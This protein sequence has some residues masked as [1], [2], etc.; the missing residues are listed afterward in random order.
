M[1]RRCFIALDI[2]EET[3][4]NIADIQEYIS[5]EKLFHGKF[6]EKENMH[7][8]LKFLGKIDD[9]TIDRIRTRLSEISME[10]FTSKIHRI[11]VFNRNNVR[12]IWVALDDDN[13]I[14]LQDNVDR[15]MEELF[16]TENR[17]MGHI[18]IARVKEVYELKR[19]LQIL[20]DMDFEIQVKIESF[21]IVESVLTR[22]GAK[23][24]TI[25][26]YQLKT[27]S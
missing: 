26:R 6:T 16:E 9:S 23:Y 7:L 18:T 27:T 21:S 12:I 10:R 24:K 2:D 14:T 15:A 8:T 22:E 13:V 19:L 4:K 25:E 11:G 17:F 3:R 20:D 1:K 5:K